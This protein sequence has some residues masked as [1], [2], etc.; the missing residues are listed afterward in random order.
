MKLNSKIKLHFVAPWVRTGMGFLNKNFSTFLGAVLASSLLFVFS[1]SK[2]NGDTGE[3][4]GQYTL[5]V[6]E[7]ENGTLTSEPEGIDC[8][9]DGDTCEAQ[10]DEGTEITLTAAPDLGYGSGAWDDDCRGAPDL[11]KC[12]LTM[13]ADKTVSKKFDSRPEVTLTVI[14]PTGGKITSAEGIDCGDGSSKC[15]VSN[16]PNGFVMTLKAEVTAKDY[17][18]GAWG[19]A[20]RREGLSK[21]CTLEMNDN[22]T[23]TKAFNSPGKK[24]LT[25]A[26]KSANGTITSSPDGINCV[27]GNGDC[28]FL[29]DYKEEVTLTAKSKAGYELGDWDGGGCSGSDATCTLTMDTDKNVKK[30]FTIIQ[31]TLTITPPT[32]GT[33]TSDDGGIDCK[34]GSSS[35]TTCEADFNHGTNVIL[36]ARPDDVNHELGDWDGGGCSGSGTTCTVAMTIDTTVAK[37]FTA[38]QHTLTITPPTNGTITS[39]A[40]DID[41]KR[42][43]TTST[44]CEA[45]F[46]HGTNVILTARPDDVNH[47]L[48]DWSGGGCLGS[49]TTCTVAMTTDKTVAKAF[50]AIQRT[51]TITRPANGAITS[52]PSG[53]NCG[54]ARSETACIRTF[55]HGTSVTLRAAPKT[56]YELGTWGGTDCV[57]EVNAATCT[58]DMTTNKTG[59]TKA[60]TIIQRTLTI[61]KPMNGTITSNPGSIN[62]GSG[63]S[64]TACSATFGHG[65]SV[66]LTAAPK[67]NYKLG[68]WGGDCSSAGNAA[69]CTLTMTTNKTGITKAFT[70]IIQRT[71]TITKPMNGTITSSP[72]GINCGESNATCE[73]DFEGGTSVTLTATPAMDYVNGVWGGDD[74]TGSGAICILTMNANKTVSK[75][76]AAAGGALDTDRDGV[77]DVDDV[78]DNGNGLI[79]IHNLDMFD[80]IRHNLAGTSYKTSSSASDNRTGAPEAETDDCTTATVDGGKSLYLCGYELTTDLDFAIAGSY[81]GDSV[82]DNWRPLDSSS[83]AIAAKDAV[84]AGFDGITDFAGTF[85][86][87]GHSISNLYSRGGGAKVGLFRSITADATIRSLGVVDANLYARTSGGNN[88]DLNGTLVGQNNGGLIIASYAKGGS[89]NN[90]KGG[91]GGLV[92]NNKGNIIA[93]YASVDINGSA[94]SDFSLGGLVGNNGTDDK[95]IGKIVASYATGNVNGNDGNEIFLGGLVGYGGEIT[96]SYATGNVDGGAGN[97]RHLGIGV[98]T[99]NDFIG[100][101]IV[102]SYG[103]GSVS[104]GTANGHGAPGSKTVNGLTLSN[105]GSKWDDAASK[106]KGAWDFGTGSQPPALRYAD[107][108]GDMAGVDYCAL[109]PAG[110]TCGTTLL[111][112]QRP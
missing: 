102:V 101:P 24:T 95:L 15:L 60:F 94:K 27:E 54:S 81:A 45:D 42:G 73:A 48:G 93:C 56:N 86:G 82:N 62:C 91:S 57:S 3:G 110:I 100:S 25:I 66:R 105:A 17:T 67:T 63:A 31:Y 108:D 107:Y 30:A 89:V 76:F 68:D 20:C 77:A 78:D 4:E 5:T 90:F 37:A 103:F 7:P 1:C 6:S 112:G 16:I 58:L 22:K 106:T 109:F 35:S 46:N 104:N 69:T 98:L 65:T 99:G 83:H 80:H 38:I 26:T 49:G 13:D 9:S 71:L 39:D 87:N 50:T 41:C 51:L 70:I 79:E 97:S 85:D 14:L 2:D 72:S 96:A 29:F 61:T 92:G 53:I 75:A 36:T 23:V 55:D 59:I 10:F 40:G 52:N 11:T 18:I 43:S 84:N 21:T 19:E 33:I 12:V 111:P 32:N 88:S 44:T 34:R 64:E 8:G 47:E 28:S 74:C